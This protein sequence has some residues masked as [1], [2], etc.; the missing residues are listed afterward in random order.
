MLNK[1]RKR[2]ELFVAFTLLRLFCTLYRAGAP[3]REME[4][5]VELGFIFFF[6]Y[7]GIAFSY[8]MFRSLLRKCSFGDAKFVIAFI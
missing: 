6:I 8:S 3:G 2:S 7:L 4:V 1:G 5:Y